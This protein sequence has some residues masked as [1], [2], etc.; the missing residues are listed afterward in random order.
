[1]PA[2]LPDAGRMPAGCPGSGRHQNK[3][4]M[5]YVSFLLVDA[6]KGGRPRGGLTSK[7]TKRKSQL[8]SWTQGLREGSL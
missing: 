8:Q 6:S 1:M 3:T 5:N 2:I 7:P 4:L